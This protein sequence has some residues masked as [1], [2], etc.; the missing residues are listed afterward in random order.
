[1]IE[2]LQNQVVAVT[3]RIDDYHDRKERRDAVDQRLLDWVFRAGFLPVTIPN[4]FFTDTISEQGSVNPAFERWLQVIKPKAILLSGGN[5]I[6]EYSER[7][8]TEFYL[9][10]WAEKK[11][12]PVLGICRGLQMMAVWAGTE[13]IPL[14]R[15]VAVRHGL[16]SSH[17]AEA[18]SWPEEVNSYH[19]WGL[20]GCPEG[21]DVTATA[22]DGSIE[23]IRHQSL[24]WQGWMWHPEREAKFDNRDTD[25]FRGLLGG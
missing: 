22:S 17:R 10:D 15:H 19:N 14:E 5:D 4:L 3:Q 9:L 21:F 13:L 11:A 8:S 12:A 25:R 6:G 1:M 16:N 2:S 20:A 7:D 23:A 24:P 18:S